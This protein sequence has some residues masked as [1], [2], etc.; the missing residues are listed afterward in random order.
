[1]NMNS[2]IDQITKSLISLAVMLMFTVALI[3]GQARANLPA[4]E[5]P[6]DELD[7]SEIAVRMD[8]S[9]I[10][11]LESWSYLLD[12]FF[13]LPIDI[14]IRIRDLSVVDDSPPDAA[15]DKLPG[16]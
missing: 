1:M 12:T 14:D 15:S 2:R 9:V 10:S 16:Q 3:A 11:K 4:R 5:S 7:R 6:V 8:R 13:A